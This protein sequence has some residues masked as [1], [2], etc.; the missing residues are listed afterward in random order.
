MHDSF[1]TL[2]QRPLMAVCIAFVIAFL[3]IWLKLAGLLQALE[4]AAYDHYI[5]LQP[6]TEHIPSAISLVKITEDDIQRFGHPL[7]DTHMAQTL[8]TLQHL[9]PAA[10]GVDIYRDQPSHGREQLRQQL[11][12]Q[13]NVFFIEKR[14]GEQVLLPGDLQPLVA[15][16]FADL[17]PDDDGVIR[18]ALLMFWDDPQ[19]T[20]FSLAV[21]LALTYLH[22]AGIQ[23]SADP[24]NPENFRLGSSVVTRLHP[25]H[26]GYSV[27]DTGGYQMLI[28]YARRGF[29]ET[30]LSALLDGKVDPQLI[31]GKVVVLGTTSSSVQDNHETPFSRAEAMPSY[32]IEIHA[33][34][35]DQL[36]RMGLNQS[37]SLK[38]LAEHYE[39]IVMI[40]LC[41]GGSFSA[42]LFRSFKSIALILIGSSLLLWFIPLQLFIAGL[43]LPTAAFAISWLS[44][45]L[46]GNIY[47]GYIENREKK[48]V[49]MLFGKYVTRKVAADL[50]QHR[51]LFLHGGHPKP[52]KLTATVLITD[53][54][55]FTTAIEKLSPE[56]ALTWL[57]RYMSSM[58]EVIEEHGGVVEDYAG[59]GIKACFGIPLPRNDAEATLDAQNAVLC[60]IAMGK[61]FVEINQTFQDQSIKLNKL[62]LGLCSGSVTAGSIG[63]EQRLS[64][65]TIG[66]TVNVAARL[67]NFDKESFDQEQVEAFRILV[68]HSTWMKL[69]VHFNTRFIGE[70]YL[71]GRQK[72]S[73]IYRIFPDF[74]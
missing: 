3:C 48:L 39:I 8:A 74:N 52:V 4:L 22:Q 10:I 63:S 47:C 60:A 25:Q 38:F 45:F 36:I 61:K 46:V 34:I 1:I 64:Y 21:S 43:W 35:I 40:L 27:V 66:D 20:H 73:K 72:I 24:A 19:Q 42:V 2:S 15:S 56:T 31:H 53:F 68:D 44:A 69:D 30:T 6:Q 54:K 5:R 59:D 67:E 51:E 16:G 18:R 33:H 14:L 49:M 57:N 29:S 12:T 13:Q 70:Y 7:D 71:K 32:G 11:N 28:D 41:F 55:N 62:R 65:T 17:T 23:Q 50:W 26:G 37:Q 9:Q 58:T